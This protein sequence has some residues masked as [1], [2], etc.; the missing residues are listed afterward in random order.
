[1]VIGHTVEKAHALRILRTR[2]HASAIPDTLIFM[3]H[4]TIF[5]ASAVIAIRRMDCRRLGI[6]MLDTTSPPSDSSNQGTKFLHG[7]FHY[8]LCIF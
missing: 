2:I 8:T 3:K 6:S 4:L 5:R 1:L 7:G